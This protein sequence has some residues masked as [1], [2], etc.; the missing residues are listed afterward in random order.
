MAR[1]FRTHLLKLVLISS[2]VAALAMHSCTKEVPPELIDDDKDRLPDQGEDRDQDGVV[3]PGETDPNAVDTDDDGINDEAE[4][5][6]LA[7]SQTNDRPFATYDVPGA[8]SVILMDA[9]ASVRQTLRTA[10]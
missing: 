1:A 2:S 5:S 10:D 3:D 6:T 9:N 4:V 7:C 8:D